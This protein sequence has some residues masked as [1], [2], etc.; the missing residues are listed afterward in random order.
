MSP[1]SSKVIN[2]EV[3]DRESDRGTVYQLY[4]RKSHIKPSI[5]FFFSSYFKSEDNSFTVLYWFLLFNNVNQP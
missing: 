3:G 5:R 4:F 1:G 2:I